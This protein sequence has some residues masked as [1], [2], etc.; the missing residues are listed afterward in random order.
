[1]KYEEKW[2]TLNR[3]KVYEEDGTGQTVMLGAFYSP[4]AMRD[5]PGTHVFGK[6]VRS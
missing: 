6:V 5:P 3:N 2:I 4:A 1:M